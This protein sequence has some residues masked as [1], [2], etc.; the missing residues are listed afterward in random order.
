MAFVLRPAKPTAL[1]ICPQA[2]SGAI[3]ALFFSLPVWADI[4]GKVVAISD[5]ERFS[6]VAAVLFRACSQDVT[7]ARTLACFASCS[8]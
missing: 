8:R 4:T 3:F 1:S 2:I 5:G 7:S 6:L